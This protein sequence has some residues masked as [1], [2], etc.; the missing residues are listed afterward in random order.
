MGLLPTRAPGGL[1]PMPP[2]WAVASSVTLASVAF[3]EIASF[4]VT[5]RG[6]G[7]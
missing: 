6:G 4:L 2:M 1:P 7:K 3:I 5:D